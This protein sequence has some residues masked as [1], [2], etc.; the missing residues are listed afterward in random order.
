MIFLNCTPTKCCLLIVDGCSL[1]FKGPRELKRNRS[2]VG[3]VVHESFANGNKKTMSPFLV[4][5]GRKSAQREESKVLTL[6]EPS[7]G[8]KTGKVFFSVAYLLFSVPLSAISGERFS[9]E[10]RADAMSEAD[11]EFCISPKL[12][13]TRAIK[14]QEDVNGLKG[15]T[16]WQTG[17]RHSERWRDNMCSDPVTFRFVHGEI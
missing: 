3:E 2:F 7:R 11:P 17:G 13:Q 6:E 16:S 15:E 12:G 9:A 14:V 8:W 5:A 1:H 10:A 4:F